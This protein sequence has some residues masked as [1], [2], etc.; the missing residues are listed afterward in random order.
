MYIYNIFSYVQLKNSS[1]PVSNPDDLLFYAVET[2]ASEDMDADDVSN[3]R[4]LIRSVK[5]VA[6]IPVEQQFHMLEGCLQLIEELNPG[7]A[8]FARFE[9]I[10]G[11][12]VDGP[13]VFHSFGV[14]VKLRW[15]RKPN[16]PFGVEGPNSPF[17]QY[18]LPVISM[19]SGNL[20]EWNGGTILSAVA[21]LGDR[22]T[23]QLA[24]VV[25]RGEKSS[26][27]AMEGWGKLLEILIQVY[28][29]LTSNR[30]AL[31]ADR[32]R[33]V[34]G[35]EVRRSVVAVFVCVCVHLY[36]SLSYTYLIC[37]LFC[38]FLYISK[39]TCLI[40]LAGYVLVASLRVL[41]MRC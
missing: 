35:R 20:Y 24:W 21:V 6:D 22:S 32:A 29:T 38:S 30:Y 3:S 25:V 15:V 1:F 10:D 33:G 2:G 14:C 23:L 18:V 7:S 9:P 28:P 26:E 27:E 16:G 36:V 5:T 13:R 34:F 37:Y 12:S 8:T 41:L 40:G 11:E 17:V 31:I 19:D 39:V 4:L